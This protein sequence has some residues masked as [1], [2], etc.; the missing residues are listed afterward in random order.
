MN[1]ICTMNCG[2]ALGDTRTEEQRRAD[3][4]DCI[5]EEPDQFRLDVIEAATKQYAYGSDDNIEIDD[6]AKIS[7]GEDGTWVQAWVFVRMTRPVG[8]DE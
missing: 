3:C 2:P 6:D 8:E 1:K 5:T 4:E 7:E